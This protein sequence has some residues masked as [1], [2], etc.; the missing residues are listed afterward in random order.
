MKN[1]ILAI[2]GLALLAAVS[3]SAQNIYTSPLKVPFAFMVGNKTMPAADYTVQFDPET[4]AVMLRAYNAGGVFTATISTGYRPDEANVDAL[5]F[6][7]FGK[8]WI[9]KRVTV[10][11]HVQMVPISKSRQEELTRLNAPAQPVLV[12]SI[13]AA[14]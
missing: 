10:G 7:R 1:R 5:Q 12:A 14:R 9:L 6:Q 2:V 11:G 3:A 4:K 8:I 13:T